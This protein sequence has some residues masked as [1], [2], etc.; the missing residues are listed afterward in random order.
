MK[1]IR[2]KYRRA[3]KRWDATAIAEESQIIKEFGLKKKREILA[4]KELLRRFR[5]RARE[6]IAKKDKMAEKVLIEKL[7]KLGL[8]KNGACLDDVLMLTIKDVL[9][10]RLQTLVY[11]KGLANTILQARQFIVHGHIAISGRRTKIPS[12]IVPVNEEEKIT[13]YGKFTK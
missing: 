7:I 9:N 2:N 8:L 11:K 12:Y 10:R 6:L 5:E 13:Y 4:T 3:K 1:R